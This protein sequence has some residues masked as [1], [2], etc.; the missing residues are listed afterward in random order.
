MADAI[1]RQPALLLALGTISPPPFS[2][3]RLAQRLTWM[4]W[5]NVGTSAPA[6]ICC[7]FV[8]RSG[9]APA[10]HAGLLERERASFGDTLLADSIAWN[11]SRVRGPVLVLAWWLQYAARA[12]RHA[13]FVGKVDDDAYLHAPDVEALLRQAS[14]LGPSAHVYLGVLTFYHWY[15]RIFE[16]TQHGWS[17]GAALERPAA[18]WCRAN[19]LKLA[20]HVEACGAEGC[21]RCVGPFV[22]ASG[23]LV[24]LSLPLAASLVA[25]GG[26][27]AEEAAMQSH[28]RTAHPRNAHTM[29]TAQGHAPRSAFRAQCTTESAATLC[30]CVLQA[31][32]RGLDPARLPDKAGKRQ[33]QVMA[34][35]GTRVAV[36]ESC[37]CCCC[38][39][40][41]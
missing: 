11:E 28:A 35:G 22:F 3:R 6:S 13:R 12:L 17:L 21:G 15:P 30:A 16:V 38:C 33:T 23:F 34:D 40:C 18:R 41:T 36:R 20:A 2:Q 7:V 29:R 14:A 10:G 5:P 4:R 37:C 1:C 31:A 39:T 24:V 9:G 25:G 19:A 32:M 8:V 26:L 27:A